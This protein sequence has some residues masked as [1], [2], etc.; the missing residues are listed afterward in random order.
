MLLSRGKEL[1]I[2]SF[3]AAQVV[4]IFCTLWRKRKGEE[5]GVG[6]LLTLA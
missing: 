3:S 1:S 2:P 5:N 4:H 6:L